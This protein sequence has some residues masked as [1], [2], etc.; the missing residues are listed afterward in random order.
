L[1][2]D[3]EKYYNINDQLNIEWSDWSGYSKSMLLDIIEYKNDNI[4][5]LYSLEYFD[6]HGEGGFNVH[7]G[8]YKRSLSG[9]KQ[10]RLEDS[11]DDLYRGCSHW[12][13][14]DNY[15]LFSIGKNKIIV[16]NEFKGTLVKKDEKKNIIFYK[17]VENNE[18]ILYELKLKI[19]D[20]CNKLYYINMNNKNY[21]IIYNFC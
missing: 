17:I 20:D 18:K 11:D 7:L 13:L 16:I 2:F 10:I 8:S 5:Y 12:Y 9:G 21:L 3:C 15:K 14:N 1:V 6:H 19:E 4:I